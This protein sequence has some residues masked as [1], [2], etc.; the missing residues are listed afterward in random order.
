MSIAAQL[1]QNRAEKLKELQKKL[2][3]NKKP[4]YEKDNRIWKP[5]FN[6]DKGKGTA[7][8]RFITPKAG[9][10]WVEVKT[11]SFKGKNGHYWDLALQT[12]NV[13]DPIQIA[14]INCFKKAK[15]ADS[16]DEQ[17][18]WK[19]EGKKYLPASK[20]YANVLVIKDEEHPE[21]EGKVMIYE[22]GRQIYLM[23]EKKLQPEFEDQVSVS[24]FDFWEGGNLRIRMIGKEIPDSKN[25]G[26]KVTVPNYEDSEFDAPSEFMG[27]DL[28]KIDAIIE[29][30]YDLS[31]FV[32]PSKFKTFDE[33]AARFLEVTGKPYD[34]LSGE[35]EGSSKTEDDLREAA[36]EQFGSVEEPKN[37]KQADENEDLPFEPDEPEDDDDDPVARFR[38]LAGG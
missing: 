23:I 38:K 3:E 12:I 14:A 17:K 36:K 37:S 34:W 24:P 2:E 32:D 19:E 25:P 21:N 4:T 16:E 30:T 18:R 27:G 1:K 10:D 8:V 20:Y 9:S 13:K 26:K 5:T 11:N 31:E 35:S 29:Q 6:K 7:I 22:F 28:D 15:N 33:L